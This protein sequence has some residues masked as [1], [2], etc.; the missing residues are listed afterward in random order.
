MISYSII[1]YILAISFYLCHCDSLHQQPVCGGRHVGGA[2]P[3]ATAPFP[4]SV[5]PQHQHPTAHPLLGRRRLAYQRLVAGGW[6]LQ[7]HLQA[8]PAATP[9]SG[10]PPALIRQRCG[11][12]LNACITAPRAMCGHANVL[13]YANV[14]VCNAAALGSSTQ[15]KGDDNN[16]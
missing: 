15:T 10:P 3:R 2:W 6:L 7:I 9:K 11:D 1:R 4:H 12:A 13:S 14:C 8:P 5:Q 16:V